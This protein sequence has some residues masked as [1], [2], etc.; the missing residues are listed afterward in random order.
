MNA[1]SVVI[2]VLVLSAAAL[3][4]WRCVKKGA[5]CECGGS[6]KDCCKN[7]GECCCCSEQ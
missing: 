5:P 4:V 2:L 1:A 7:G 3:A 6:H